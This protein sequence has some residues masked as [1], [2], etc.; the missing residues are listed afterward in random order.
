MAKLWKAAERE[1]ARAL[2]GARHVREHR[3]ESSGDVDHGF[4]S[5]ECKSRRTLPKW[6]RDALAQAQRYHP[7]RPP[8]VVLREKGN[9]EAL[10]LARLEDVSAWFGA[11]REREALRDLDAMLGKP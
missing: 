1:A 9:R 8:V 4:L 5:V 11:W 6:L 2:G 3:F 10:V 7:D